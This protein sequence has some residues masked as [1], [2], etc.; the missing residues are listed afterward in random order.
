MYI[1]CNYQNEI[2]SRAAASSSSEN[3]SSCSA[4][5]ALSQISA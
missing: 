4:K 3:F 2:E 5:R 1:I